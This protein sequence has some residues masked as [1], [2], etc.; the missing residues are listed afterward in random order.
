MT[1]RLPLSETEKRLVAERK[2]Q[3]KT[4]QEIAKE[5]SCSYETARKWWRQ[6]RDKRES[7]PRGRPQHGILSTFPE[8]LRIAAIE[9]K[10][11][12]PGWGAPNVLIELGTILP[13]LKGRLP[14]R[15]RLCAL[16]QSECPSS[17][18]P[19]E[20]RA[21]P[22]KALEPVRRPHERWQMDA[23]EGVRVGAKDYANILD[24]RDPI[25]A[26]VIESR[27]FLTSTEKRWRK[28]NLPEIQGA[29]R[30]AFEKWGMPLEVQTDHEAV[31]VGSSDHNFPSPF[32]LWLVGLGIDHV[33]SRTHRPTD[34][35]QCERLHRT[36]AD[37][38]WR[39]QKI[40]NLEELQRALDKHAHRYNEE[41]PVQA[42]QCAGQPPLVA[43][44]EARCSG[45]LYHPAFE[46]DLFDMKRVEQ[47]LSAKVWVRKVT[48]NGVVS[49][50]NHHYYVGRAFIG[51][52]VS[53][54]FIPETRVFRICAAD[55][56][57]LRDLPAIGLTKT[58]LIGF[59]PADRTL[60]I[61]FQFPLLL[62]GV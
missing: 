15:A 11:S 43:H 23:K 18:Q 54:Q 56:T 9:I 35:A 50:G 5:L 4:L 6:K 32:T 47:F 44:P 42:A 36:L 49:F 2:E 46:W 55:G 27:A 7:Q 24:I 31:Y 59:I 29:L 34:Q 3:G 21:Y 61:G 51:Q 26:L 17:V 30:L 52:S 20:P 13:D 16:F 48:G 10:K 57:F 41:L 37:M 58:D 40:E 33:T 53:G 39:D 28:I 45:R 25:G 1:H 8:Q 12:H 14:S 60:P 22:E 62:I 38:A 19:H